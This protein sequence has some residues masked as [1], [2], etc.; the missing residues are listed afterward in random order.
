MTMNIR[1]FLLN[2]FLFSSF[3]EKEISLLETSASLKKVGKG[4]QIF[5]EG[6][7]ATAF[8][9]VVSGKVKIYKLSPDGKEH[10][11]H[12]QSPG[13]LVAEAAI[14]DAMVYPAS[15]AA[16]ED[17]TLVRISGEG[18]RNLIRVHPELSLKMM[19]GYSRRLRQ[20]VV[21]IEEL[22]LKD[23]KT[24]LAGYII[25]NSSL[26]NGA[27]VCRLGYSKKELASLLGT[28]PETFSRA[29]AFLKQK[30]LIVEKDNTILVPDPEKLRMFAE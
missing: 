25:E 22:S 27:T 30:K 9:I 6:M 2:T 17:S 23:I 18:L 3:S 15:C 4:E 20:F 14:F 5:S 29:L 13:D 1:T 24:R 12:I 28:I 16:L 7:E 19:S 21:K 11:L 10:T 26:E 8:F